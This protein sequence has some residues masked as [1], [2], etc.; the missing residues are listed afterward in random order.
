MTMV[1]PSAGSLVAFLVVVTMVA[2]ALVWGVYRASLVDGREV[3][4]R[5]SL[6]VLGGLL[7]WNGL[8]GAFVASGALA[9]DYRLAMPFLGISNLVGLGVALSPVGGWLARLPATWLVAFQAFRLP[10]ELVLHAWG[11]QGTI[12]MTMTWEGSNLDVITGVAAL[13]LAPFAER[14]AVA[15][16][17]SALGLGLLVNVARVAVLSSP[18]DFSWGQ[19]PPLLLAMFVPLYLIVPV[20]VAG[21]L[22][23]HVVLLRKLLDR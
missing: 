19:E 11:E 17:F 9:A 8:L 21:A 1:W 6:A 20:C 23:G 10:L 12:P 5:R 7:L 15:W 14:R 3:A 16:L 18:F 2:S 13:L 22:C 4:R